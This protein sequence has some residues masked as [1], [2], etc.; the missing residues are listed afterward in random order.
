MEYI[1]GYKYTTEAKAKVAVKACNEYYLSS[2]PEGN[3]TTT[4]VNYQAA[5][6]NT[7]NFFYIQHHASLNEVLGD[8]IDFEV[9]QDII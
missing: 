4:W 7:T 8:P 2:I 5:E 3:V 1:N 6:L 9:N